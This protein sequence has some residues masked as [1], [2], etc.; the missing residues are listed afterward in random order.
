MALGEAMACGLPVVST[1]CPSGP[2]QLI[3]PGIDG[4]LVPP[5]D[6]GALAGALNALMGDD[7]LRARLAARAPEVLDRFGI[8]RIAARWDELFAEV[9][10]ERG[11]RR[12]RR[13]RTFGSAR[14]ASP[15]PSRGYDGGG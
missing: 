9:I 6:P 7:D 5:H 2:R 8:E 4:M 10:A 12:Q 3:R 15:I 14:T 13:F 1:D 11:Q